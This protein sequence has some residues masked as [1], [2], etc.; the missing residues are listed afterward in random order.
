M[1]VLSIGNSFSQDAQR[2]VYKIAKSHG[3]DV[4]TDNLYIGACSLEKHYN[5]YVNDV[6]EYLYERN[7]NGL[8]VYKHEQIEVVTL[9]MALER[10]K[11]DI[12][13]LQQVSHF[14]FNYDTYFPYVKD[15]VEI[16]KK[17][18]PQAKIYL[19]QTWAYENGCE[20]LAKV[21]YK[22]ASDM[23]NDIETAYAKVEKDILASGLIPSGLAVMKAMNKGLKVHRDTLHVSLGLG[24]FMLALVWL[25]TLTGLDV[26]CVNFND[27]DEEVSKDD[28]K[29]AIEIVDEL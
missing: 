9:K 2:Y 22:T 8:G 3:V 4:E 7:G 10:E 5:N 27:F 26:K 18:Q 24:R 6:K 28:I 17:Y 13:T 29:T 25:K 20:R 12:I 19:H 14:S 21:G 15:L 11:Y 16:V 1:K 23:F